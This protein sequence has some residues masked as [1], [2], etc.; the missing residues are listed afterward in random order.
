MAEVLE[1]VGDLLGSDATE[2]ERREMIFGE[3]LGIRG[4][5]AVLGSTADEFGEEKDFV[6]MKGVGRMAVQIAVEEGDKLGDA[7]VVAGFFAGFA[8]GGDG[9]R[10][11][12]I[13]P[14]AG[15]GPATVLEF[16]DKEDAAI[17]ES[18]N[19]NIDFGRGVTGL[20]GEEILKGS[21]TGESGASG[22]HLGGKVADLVVAV[23][24]ELVLAIGEPGLGDGLE[25]ARPDEPL[26]NGHEAILAAR[27]VG[28]KARVL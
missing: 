19:A 8:G 11:T 21:G 7:D 24:I 12:D 16:P 15:E 22:H 23:N 6:G 28:D 13:G 2:R 14:T 9:G 25:A 18:G 20:L 27:G 17:P 3:E 26:G 10:L 5:V 1:D 4:F